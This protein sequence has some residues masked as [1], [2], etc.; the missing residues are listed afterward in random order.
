MKENYYIYL[1]LAFI[2]GYFANSIIKQI[3][4]QNIEGVDGPAPAPAPAPGPSFCIPDATPA[5]MCPGNIECP[6]CGEDSCLCPTAPTCS[7]Y[8][9]PH[10]KRNK[11]S[12]SST[13]LLAD[14]LQDTQNCCEN[15]PPHGG[16]DAALSQYACGE[17]GGQCSPCGGNGGHV[18]QGGCG[19]IH[20]DAQ[21]SAITEIAGL[22][23]WAPASGSCEGG[24][25]G[26][27]CGAGGENLWQN[28]RCKY[29]AV[30]DA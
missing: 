26:I 4:G 3:C 29:D 1:L 16:T 12:A 24:P 27:W 22:G 23:P 20:S 25:C 14:T 11:Q 13:I 7:G 15:I 2:L 30:P 17:P 10:G 5:Q 18:E 28:K 19:S 21:R 6:D 8:N 9:C